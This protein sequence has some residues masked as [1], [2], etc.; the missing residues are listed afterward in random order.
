MSSAEFARRRTDSPDDNQTIL[1]KTKGRHF[2][3]IVRD[4]ES[5]FLGKIRKNSS[6]CRLNF[7]PSM[8]GVDFLSEPDCRH[9][10][11]QK[12]CQI[13]CTRTQLIV[14]SLKACLRR[15]R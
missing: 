14:L 6:K 11:L 10:V 12:N 3:Q 9:T 1:S 13:I 15:N 7:V 4:V 5:Y 2:M 8:L